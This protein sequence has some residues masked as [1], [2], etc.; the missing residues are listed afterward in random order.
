MSDIGNKRDDNEDWVTTDPRLDQGNI[1]SRRLS[2]A[3]LECWNNLVEPLL[4]RVDQVL[5]AHHVNMKE[6]AM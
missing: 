5:Q 2:F 4:C 1:G 3:G 6:H